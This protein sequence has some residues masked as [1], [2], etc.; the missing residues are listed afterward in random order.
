MP[1]KCWRFHSVLFHAGSYSA[2]KPIDSTA[3]HHIYIYIYIYTYIY[4]YIYIYIYNIYI[5]I[6]IHIYKARRLGEFRIE[7]AGMWCRAFGFI[8]VPVFAFGIRCQGPRIT[9]RALQR[10]EPVLLSMHFLKPYVIE[11]RALHPKHPEHPVA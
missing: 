11:P 4:I 7:D 2:S 1:D 9:S 10:L 8:A 3:L 5:Y 6:Y